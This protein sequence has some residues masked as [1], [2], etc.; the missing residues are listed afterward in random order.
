MNQGLK[1]LIEEA[2]ELMEK[3]PKKFCPPQPDDD[4]MYSNYIF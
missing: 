4:F 1:D 2:Y 3:H